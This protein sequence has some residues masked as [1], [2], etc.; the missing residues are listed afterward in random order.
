MRRNHQEFLENKQDVECRSISGTAL[1][2][3]RDAGNP[4]CGWVLADNLDFLSAEGAVFTISRSPGAMPQANRE[5][6][7]LALTH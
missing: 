5:A 4:A 7:P 6:A 3:I 1:I 2:S